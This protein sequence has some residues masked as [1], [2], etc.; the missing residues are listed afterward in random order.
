VLGVVVGATF[1]S[2]AALLPA[3]EGDDLTQQLHR[4]LPMS[5]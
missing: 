1:N 2:Y 3:N 4:G 5:D